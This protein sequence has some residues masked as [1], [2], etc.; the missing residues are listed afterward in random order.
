MLKCTSGL[1][2]H[3]ITMQPTPGRAVLCRTDSVRSACVPARCVQRSDGVAVLLPE[4]ARTIM[5]DLPIRTSQRRGSGRVVRRGKSAAAETQ[6]SAES[7]AASSASAP[8]RPAQAANAEP[9]ARR[10]RASE[11]AATSYPAT[12]GGATAQRE[13]MIEKAAYYRAVARGFAPGHEL[14]DWVAAEREVDEINAR[15]QL[16]SVEAIDQ[17]KRGTH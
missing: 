10:T 12:P 8:S 2:G 5:T 6:P 3:G 17:A 16:E 4:F 14:E 15:A 13:G 11:T 1:A 7:R 9:R